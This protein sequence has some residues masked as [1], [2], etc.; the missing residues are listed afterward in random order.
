MLELKGWVVNI[1]T[2]VFFITAIEMILPENNMKKYAKFV[3]GLI[4]ITVL[5]NPLVMFLNNGMDMNVFINKS[6]NYIDEIGSLDKQ[7]EYREES[8]NGTLKVFQSNLEALCLK[9]IKEKYEKDNYEVHAEVVYDK[10]KEE[11]QVKKL[12]IGVSS[13]KVEKVQRIEVKTS[14]VQKNDNLEPSEMSSEIT[15]YLSSELEISKN[16]II[17]YKVKA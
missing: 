16:I 5:I 1:C 10:E 14:G 4:L 9:K 3:F 2:A 15:N 8:I 17:V 13:N 11:Y 7:L 12:L 6:M